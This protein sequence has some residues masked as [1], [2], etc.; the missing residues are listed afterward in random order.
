MRK[1]EKI[2]LAGL[3]SYGLVK[4]LKRGLSRRKR[5]L[6][7]Q[8][9]ADQAIAS[10]RYPIVLVHGIFFRDSQLFDYWGRIPA[11]LRSNGAQVFHGKQ[12][13]TVPIAIAGEQLKARILSILELTGADKV[14]IIAHSKG[15]LDSR[16]AISKLGLAEYVASL[17]TVNTPHRGSVL[18]NEILSKTPS[19]LVERLSRHYESLLT[20]L[21]DQKIDL[22]ASL[23][24]LT[25]E[26]ATAFNLEVLD[27]PAV[28]YQSL[29]SK[30]AGPLA[31]TSIFGLGYQIIK[32]LAGDNDGLVPLDS[33]PWGNYLGTV[34]PI[35]RRG[36]S[37]AD[38]VDQAKKDYEDFEVL[39]YYVQ[40]VADLKAK[41]F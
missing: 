25:P 24:D 39:E 37:H 6:L 38:M 13:S 34:T 31:S 29:G 2:I 15:G 5:S 23:E 17:T 20:R 12:D 14:N 9:R 21:G 18:A 35:G 27:H 36:I 16:Y 8:G 32:P 7:N 26:Q 19:Q 22:I 28:Y 1:R 33:M 30:L 4:L 40:L 11:E 41:G 10:T 3:A